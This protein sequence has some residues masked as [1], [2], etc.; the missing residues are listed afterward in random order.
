MRSLPAVKT[1]RLSVEWKR[2]ARTLG[3]AS[4]SSRVDRSAVQTAVFI[5]LTG[6]RW[7][8]TVARASL[9]E[10]ETV[11]MLSAMAVGRIWAKGGQATREL[12]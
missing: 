5:E 6:S 1:L 9:R 11:R 4:R 2:T 3:F 10:Y 8:D 12:A 7:R